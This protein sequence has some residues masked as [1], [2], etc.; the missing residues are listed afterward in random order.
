MATLLPNPV[1]YLNKRTM[2]YAN[3]ITS[4]EADINYTKKNPIIGG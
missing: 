1:V 4:L 3:E 2:P